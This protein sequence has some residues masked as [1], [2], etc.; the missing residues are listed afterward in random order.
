M[1]GHRR[2]S[3]K[4]A[5]V[6]FYFD[7]DI[8][9]LAKVIADLRS[10]ATYPGAPE[11]E[12][13]GRLRPACPVTSTATKDSV[14]IPSVAAAGWSIITRDKRIERKPAE[15][16]AVLDSGARMFAITS[17]DQLSKWDQLE[18][19]MRRW[20]DIQHLAEDP[21]PFIYALTY[22]TYRQIL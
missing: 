12:I 6:R 8:L 5:D 15:R 1:S 16:E 7:A 9:G 2:R 19:L 13:N 3:P 11:A 21:G 10:D 22:S 14:W 18:I 4:P 17:S 20:R